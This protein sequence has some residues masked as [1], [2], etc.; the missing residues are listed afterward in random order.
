M[1][2]HTMQRHTMQR[3]TMQ[4]P[5][6]GRLS[7][8]HLGAVIRPAAASR[9]SA[10]AAT[11]PPAAVRLAG[12]LLALA[13][14]AVHI[15]DQGGITAFALPDWLGW[16]YRL[17]EVGGALVALVLLWPWSGRFPWVGWAS[18]TLLGIGPLIGYL[19][20]RSVG[21]PGDPEDVGNWSDWLGTTSLFLEAALVAVSIGMLLVL[22]PLRRALAGSFTAYDEHRTGVTHTPITS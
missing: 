15:A 22:S 14:S 12:A 10:P 9:A 5:V 17:I 8:D 18:A 19:A 3:H 2:R 4:R 7:S 1:Q 11:L 13:V 6:T 21:V 16:A 20:S